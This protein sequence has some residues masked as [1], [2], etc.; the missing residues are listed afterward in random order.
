[1][2]GIDITILAIV[3]LVALSTA[4]LAYGILFTR[5]ETE[6]KAEREKILM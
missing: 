1:M 5:I 3:G 6:K 4:G 2:F